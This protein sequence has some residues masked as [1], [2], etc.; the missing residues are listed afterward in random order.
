MWYGEHLPDPSVSLQELVDFKTVLDREYTTPTLDFTN[1]KHLS[2]A[3]LERIT[4]NRVSG[5]WE[6]PVY[7]DDK[8]RARYGLVSDS[9][10]GWKGALAHR[11]MYMVFFGTNVP[12]GYVIDHLCCEKACCYPRHL[13]WQ[14]ITEGH[15]EIDSLKKLYL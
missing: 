10:N 6:L 12:E 7:Q 4:H 14:R 15:V 2:P 13:Q 8:N 11:V 9:E 3:V 5:C 1:R